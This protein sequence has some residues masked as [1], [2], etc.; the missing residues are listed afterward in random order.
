MLVQNLSSV[1]FIANSL[2]TIEIQSIH[3]FQIILFL[4]IIIFLCI[5]SSSIFIPYNTYPTCVSWM[6]HSWPME[7]P[8]KL[9]TEGWT[10]T[11]SFLVAFGT[12]GSTVDVIKIQTEQSREIIKNWIIIIYCLHIWMIVATQDKIATYPWRQKQH[13]ETLHP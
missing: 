12:D 2:Y 1:I 11:T 10:R 9:I 3:V 7:S 4:I 8:H 6:I 13:H 5:Y